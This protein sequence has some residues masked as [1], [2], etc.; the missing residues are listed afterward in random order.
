ML[1]LGGFSK[2]G[3]E[4][5]GKYIFDKGINI[6]FCTG[7]DAGYY[8]SGAKNAGMDAQKILFFTDREKM[9]GEIINML[10]SG[11]AVL[12]KGSR[13][14]KME[15]VLKPVVEGWKRE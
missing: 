1:E 10:R 7:K 14:T 11:D 3:H 2:A 5:I 4:Q 13:S 15:D 6:L 9:C 12:F 8:A